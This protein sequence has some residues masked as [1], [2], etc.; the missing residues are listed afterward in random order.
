MNNEF[1]K[2]IDFKQE[3]NVGG[4]IETA[5]SGQYELTMKSV[6]K[7]AFHH[8]VRHFV[9]FSPAVIVLL[10]LQIGIIYT[11]LHMQLGDLQTIFK[12]FS[13]PETD[14]MVWNAISIATLC[15]E[16]ISAPIYVGLCMMAVSHAVGLNTQFRHIMRGFSFTLP[17]IVVTL[18]CLGAQWVSGLFLPVVPLYLSLTF[19]FAPLLICEKRVSIWQAIALSFRAVNKKIMVLAAIHIL[20]LLMFIVAIMFY[21]I[22]LIVVMPFFFHVKAVLYREMFGVQLKMVKRPNASPS[23]EVK[24]FDA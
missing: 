24:Q 5:L 22:G 11:A 17:V 8:T 21:G 19:T 16:A 13:D 10:I 12:Q 3:I 9:S 4:R 2:E 7:E 18:L 1:E 6:V 15:N 23:Q 20:L 14:F